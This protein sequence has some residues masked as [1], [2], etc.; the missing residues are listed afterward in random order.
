MTFAF[1]CGGT[2][3][4]PSW[5]ITA[6]YCIREDYC[7]IFSNILM[8]RYFLLTSPEEMLKKGFPIKVGETNKKQMNGKA[9]RSNV[10]KIIFHPKWKPEDLDYDVVMLQVSVY[11]TITIEK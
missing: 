7:M 10:T 6:A 5:V 4:D 8:A 3:I 9:Q 2:L 11:N 1:G